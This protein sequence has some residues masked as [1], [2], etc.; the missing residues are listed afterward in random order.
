MRNIKTEIEL[1]K[2]NDAN[3]VKRLLMYRMNSKR[4]LRTDTEK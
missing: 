4:R 2:R 1:E 3:R